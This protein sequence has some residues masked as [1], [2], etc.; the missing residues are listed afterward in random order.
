MLFRFERTAN[1]RTRKCFL[2]QTAYLFVFFHFF[3]ESFIR[4][5]CNTSIIR[6]VIQ[7]RYNSQK[8]I[9]KLDY[10]TLRRNCHPNKPT[11][12]IQIKTSETI[13]PLLRKEAG[14][15]GCNI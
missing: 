15:N 12:N 9:F 2:I 11:V 7:T 5:K 1:Q 8:I 3:K 4:G 10:N 6:H 14:S 13:K